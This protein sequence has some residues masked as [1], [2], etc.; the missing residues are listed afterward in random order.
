MAKTKAKYIVKGREDHVKQVI[1]KFEELYNDDSNH[2][3]TEKLNRV[4]SPAEEKM[5]IE[6]A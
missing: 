4:P 6:Y 3:L 1:A 5:I 2:F